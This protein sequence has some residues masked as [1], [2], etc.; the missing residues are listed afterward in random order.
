MVAFCLQ[1][2][3]ERKQLLRVKII[4][5]SNAALFADYILPNTQH[6]A[7]DI[8]P[9]V[10]IAYAMCLGPLAECSLRFLTMIDN[11]RLHHGKTAAA[12][13]E[14]AAGTGTEDS[15]DARLSELQNMFEEHVIPLLLTDTVPQVRKSLT[16]SIVQLCLFFGRSR[17]SDILLSRMITFLN[18]KDWSLRSAFFESAIDFATCI[19]GRSLDDYILPL[20]DQALD[21]QSP[22]I[23]LRMIRE[24]LRQFPPIRL[25]RECAMACSRLLEDIDR[26][27]LFKEGPLVA[28]VAAFV[29]ALLPSEC[30]GKKIRCGVFM[31]RCAPAIGKRL[32]VRL[33]SKNPFRPLGGYQDSRTCERTTESPQTGVSFSSL[34]LFFLPSL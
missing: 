21:G 1:M 11:I 27:W 28:F 23:L 31:S 3:T 24:L 16:H 29:W 2:E 19:G 18:D 8:D 5:M 10:R 14:N 15:F 6:L 34:S 7:T 12:I 4:T 30:L 22:P 26:T 9:I 13:D 33:V 25:R 20:V 17:A 32:V